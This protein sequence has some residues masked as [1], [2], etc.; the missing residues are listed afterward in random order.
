MDTGII[1]ALILINIDY[2]QG[3]VHI[4]C[5]TTYDEDYGVFCANSRPV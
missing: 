5:T 3:F 1:L 2:S 4:Q